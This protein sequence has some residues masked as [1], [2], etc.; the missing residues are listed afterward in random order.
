[1]GQNVAAT[2]G[3]D[4]AGGLGDLFGLDLG[5]GG[6]ADLLLVLAA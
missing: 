6:L 5:E 1:V 4:E 3:A 2:E